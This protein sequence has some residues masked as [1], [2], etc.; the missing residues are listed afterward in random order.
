MTGGSRKLVP[1]KDNLISLM[2]DAM[3]PLRGE[4]V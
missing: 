4:V 3:Q 1:D 2:L